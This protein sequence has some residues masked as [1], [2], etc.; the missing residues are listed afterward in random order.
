M[1]CWSQGEDGE[2]HSLGINRLLLGSR[3]P[4]PVACQDHWNVVAQD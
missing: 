3:G 1:L 4:W 2:S